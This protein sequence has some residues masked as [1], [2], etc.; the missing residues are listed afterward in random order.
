[1]FSAWCLLVPLSC[2]LSAVP[3]MISS[4]SSDVSVMEG[5]NVSLFCTARGKPEPTVSWRAVNHPAK[6]YPSGEQLD[7]RGIAREQ[8]GEYE[9]S[10]QNGVS[11]PSTKTLRVTVNY[12]PTIR[13]MK[14]TRSALTALLRCDALGA[15]TP[16]F[17]W[18]RGSKRLT[19]GHGTRIQTLG[20]HSWSWH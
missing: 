17:E 19:A 12:P 11:A 4:V 5:G 20:S 1:M 16:A 15:P 2:A 7:I 14:F 10:A 13:E 8:A 18:Y 6:K 3:A 9:C